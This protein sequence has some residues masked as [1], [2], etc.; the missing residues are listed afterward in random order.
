MNLENKRIFL[1][2]RRMIMDE[3]YQFPRIAVSPGDMP[4]LDLLP[5]KQYLKIY[6]TR[7]Y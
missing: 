6:I 7:V 1:Y 2:D 5:G 3:N 4:N